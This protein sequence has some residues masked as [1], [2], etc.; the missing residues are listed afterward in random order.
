VEDSQD[1]GPTSHDFTAP[2]IHVLELVWLFNKFCLRGYD[3]QAS[4]ESAR[5]RLAIYYVK[6]LSDQSAIFESLGCALNERKFPPS[7]SSTFIALV[8]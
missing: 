4:L 5:R 1:H 2:K 6:R 7:P 3:M 8:P